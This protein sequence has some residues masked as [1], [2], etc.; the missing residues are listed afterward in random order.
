MLTISILVVIFVHCSTAFACQSKRV[1]IYFSFIIFL[2][3]ASVVVLLFFLN[4][5]LVLLTGFCLC[6]VVPHMG[7]CFLT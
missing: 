6:V 7:R 4:I 2:L 1:H 3:F 5:Q